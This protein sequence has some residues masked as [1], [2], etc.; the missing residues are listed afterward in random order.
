[1]HSYE[2]RWKFKISDRSSVKILPSNINIDNFSMVSV[3]SKLKFPLKTE[4]KN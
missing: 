2:G 4:E 3:D 1:V